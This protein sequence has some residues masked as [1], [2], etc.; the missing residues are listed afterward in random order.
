MSFEVALVQNAKE[1]EAVFA[2]RMIVFVEEQ[3]VPAEEELDAYDLTSTHF[4]VRKTPGIS[5]EGEIV[6]TARLIDKGEGTGKVGR[7]AVLKEYR[8]QGVGALLMRYVEEYAR[9]Q[10]FRKLALDAQMTALPFYERLGYTAE[11]DIFL[12]CDIEHRFMW[13]RLD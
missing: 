12:D 8:G 11:G 10:G 2:V 13:K 9:T 7:V 4:C 6:A 1:Q 3:A 5:E